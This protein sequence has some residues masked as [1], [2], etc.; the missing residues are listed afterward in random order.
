MVKFLLWAF[1]AWKIWLFVFLLFAVVFV[2]LRLHFLGGGLTHYIA[3]PWFWAWSNF[4]GEHYLS[5][6]QHGY[7]EGEQA[8]FP[9]YPLLMRL[10]V[11]PLRGDLFWLNIGGLVISHL[12]F[13]LALFGLWKLLSLDFKRG[14]VE[15]ALI[16]LLVFPTS[17]YFGSVYT[18][19]LFFALVVWSFYA[20]RR[21]WW[22]WAGILGGL[23][24]STRFVGILL[25]PAL[26]TEW[27]AQ[28]R[29]VKFTMYNL[30]FLFL[31][32]IPIGL[33]AYMYYLYQ[34][35]GDPLAF[36]HALPTFGEQR[37]AV[38]ILL[39]QVFWRY[40]KIFRDAN[41][42]DPFFF[43]LILEAAA[44]VVFL[45]LSMVGFIKLR[46]SYALFLFLGYLLPT[47]SGSFS[48]LPRYVLPLFPAFLLA[49]V[50]LERKPLWVKVGVVGLLFVLLGA[51]TSL[52]VRGYW[53]A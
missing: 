53:I 50:L 23:A 1:V 14:V 2:P 3:N 48:S 44:A 24:S 39:P 33:L 15:L 38:P 18:E 27:W 52:F 41:L 22:L 21:G 7:G 42:S 31:F 40:F 10:L 26:L 4:D 46:L 51:A 43:T 11:W 5:I 36:W 13:L 29:N 49:A 16:L 20:A 35:T 6:A 25:L 19:S 45:I 32:I 8:F 9:L 34:T 12:S 28:R 30:Q 37:S 17:F 47:F